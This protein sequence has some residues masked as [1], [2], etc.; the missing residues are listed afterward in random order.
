MH[1]EPI[2]FYQYYFTG[3]EK[4]IIME[5]ENRAMADAM[6]EEFGSRI[7]NNIPYDRLMDIRIEVPVTG[8]SKRIRN[9]E[10]Y[11]WVGTNRSRDGWMLEEEFKKLTGDEGREKD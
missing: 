2:K 1:E 6:L 11:V 8:I 5:A 4:P 10:P 9:G 3:V 7:G